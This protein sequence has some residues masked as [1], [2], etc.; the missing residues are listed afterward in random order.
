MPDDIVRPPGYVLLGETVQPG[1]DKMSSGVMRL[2]TI[3][4]RICTICEAD[5]NA[6]MIVLDH[7]HKTGRNRG[8]LCQQCNSWLGAYEANLRRTKQRGRRKFWIWLE[9][10]RDII[11]EYLARPQGD[12]HSLHEILKHGGPGGAP[13]ISESTRERMLQFRNAV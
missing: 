12:F 9:Q 1:P 11:S 3:Q 7:D 10:Y 5:E 6:V 13:K 8:L 2:P 4:A